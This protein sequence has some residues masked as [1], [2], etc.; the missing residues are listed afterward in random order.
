MRIALHKNE[1]HLMR[2]TLA[3][4]IVAALL[5]TGSAGAFAQDWTGGY[6]G[7]YL[8]NVMDPDD[9]DDR[10]LFDTNLDGNF[11]DSVNTAA[12]ANAFSPGFCDGAANDRTPAGGCDGNTGGAEWGLRAGY[13]WQ[14]DAFVYGLVLEY[15]YSDARDAVSAFS[16]TPA[17]YTMLRKVDDTLALRARAGLTFGDGDNLVYGTA[18]YARAS[19]ENFF[20]TSN[21]ANAFTSS[22]DTDADGYQFG[23]GYER[24]FSDNFSM[25]IEYIVSQ[26]D[27]EDARINVARGTAPATNPFLIVNA[28]GTDFRRSDDQLDLDSLRLTAS[29][30]F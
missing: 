19:I 23:A 1:E 8:G 18:G 14:A 22:G 21:G 27:D 3:A 30:R 9:S 25:G 17:Y 7:G 12:G 20:F 4:S 29:W 24:R 11:N 2:H 15:G 16:T 10:I 26:L 6:V 13:D 28:S 5:A